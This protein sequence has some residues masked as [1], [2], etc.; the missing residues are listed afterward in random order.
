[1]RAAAQQL[2]AFVAE[3]R[4]EDV[5]DE[6][7]ESAKLHAL[8]ALG[9]GLAAHALDEAPWVALAAREVAASGLATAI[10]L[11]GGLPPGEAALV[12]GT[13][14]HA[15]DYDDTHP[16]AVAHVSAAVTPA[17][18]AAGELH[19]SDGR[20]VICALVAGNETTVRLGTAGSGRFHARGLHPTGVCNVF[21]AA[22]AAARLRGLD[23]ERTAHALGIAASM[24]SGVMEF[25]ADGA[26]TKPLHPGWAANAG[27]AAARLAAHG[28]TGPVTGIDGRRGFF[29]AYLHGE[30]I[31]V[32]AELADLGTRWATLD[33]AFKPYP[34]C[35]YTHA[36]LDALAR[37]IAGEGLEAAD[38]ASIVGLT[39][40]TGIDL[41]LAPLEDKLRPRTVYDAKF[42]L[43]YC[44]ATLL[45][46]GAVGVESFTAAAIAD[47]PVLD[48][49]GRVTGERRHYDGFG[50]GVRVVTRDGRTLE[51]ELRHQRGGTENPMT[52]DE[53]V[54]KWRAN[55]GLA[56]PEDLWRELETAVLGL[57]DRPDLSAL[58]MLA[59]ERISAGY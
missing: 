32:A 54:G 19:G 11:P 4:Y 26:K 5:P 14:C 56:L 34:A 51:A 55:A 45:V 43:P 2:A 15:L 12:N 9:C 18:L 28:A 53:I 50:G 29:G 1:M 16:R 25:L 57:E 42:S 58:S 38:V 13:L 30:T 23:A 40:Q 59:G 10:G 49:A 52:A 31:D 46:N 41:V 35:H 36:P 47:P 39:D 7:V 48:V 33:I 20:D 22:A 27:L 6:V 37:L 3:L 24:A 21:G 17:A 8:D 44:L